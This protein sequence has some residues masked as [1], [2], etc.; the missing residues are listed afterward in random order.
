MSETK[1]SQRWA[2]IVPGEDIVHHNKALLRL[3]KDADCTW[4]GFL[5]LALADIL[6]LINRYGMDEFDTVADVIRE[7]DSLKDGEHTEYSAALDTIVV[8]VMEGIDYIHEGDID[9]NQEHDHR[10]GAAGDSMYEYQYSVIRQGVYDLIKLI[11]RYIPKMFD[12]PS[13]RHGV[14]YELVLD[15]TVGHDLVFTIGYLF[16]SPPSPSHRP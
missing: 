8:S 1:S 5:Q 6:S 2:F 15:R 14:P 12:E 13:G 4:E 11:V 9:T 7:A 16:P 3:L 10:H